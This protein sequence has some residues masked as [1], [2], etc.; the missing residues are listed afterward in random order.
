MLISL[1]L[2]RGPNCARKVD[3]WLVVAQRTTEYSRWVRRLPICRLMTGDRDMLQ[4][5]SA[6]EASCLITI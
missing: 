2:M 4:I 3:V 5:E 6:R 1:M